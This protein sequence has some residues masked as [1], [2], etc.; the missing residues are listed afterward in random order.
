MNKK[1]LKGALVFVLCAFF[2]VEGSAK[3][4][5]SPSFLLFDNHK[6]TENIYVS[7]KTNE[8]QTYK[9]SILH[10]KMN[11]KGEYLKTDTPAKG[12]GFADKILRYGPRRIVLEPGQTQTLRVQK[13]LS[14]DLPDGEYRSHLF[15]LE[16]VK[17]KKATAKNPLKPNEMSVVVQS[18]FGTTIPVVVRKGDL[19]RTVKI[20]SIT[21]EKTKKG[22]DALK[23]I[24]NRTGSK[25]VI[26]GAVKAFVDGEEVAKISNIHCFLSTNKRIVVLPLTPKDK[27]SLSGEKI[28]IKFFSSQKLGAELLA[29]GHIVYP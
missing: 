29:E 22:K 11:E 19:Q 20:S 14:A 23:I 9:V 13:R 26:S 28:E 1:I 10:Y 25:S 2:T 8:K 21:P 17:V 18:Q 7:N 15:L 3:I 4:M 16:R 6:R 5:L 24:I 12:E 27:R